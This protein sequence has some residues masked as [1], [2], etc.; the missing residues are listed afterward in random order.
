[1]ANVSKTTHFGTVSV[2]IRAAF[3]VLRMKMSLLI[4]TNQKNEEKNK[5]WD[6]SCC[7]HSI[8]QSSVI[9]YLTVS[10]KKHTI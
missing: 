1:M 5:I 8:V 10:H 4:S 2:N 9:P 7:F 6:I 3:N